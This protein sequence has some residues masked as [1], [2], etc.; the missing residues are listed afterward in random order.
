MLGVP[1]D[2]IVSGPTLARRLK[3]EIEE[4]KKRMNKWV[5]ETD[6]AILRRV[7]KTGE[8]LAELLKVTNR[9][10][11]QGYDGVDP[12]TDVP[13]QVSLTR[14]I[15]DVYAQLDETVERLG[16]DANY[17]EVRRKIKRGYM[18]EWEEMFL[19]ANVS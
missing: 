10:V 4:P 12:E 16:L 18:Q 11:I 9:I 2:G 13:N 6:P 19:P 15:A 1:L 17:I 8:E 14:E 3:M 5:P 7:G